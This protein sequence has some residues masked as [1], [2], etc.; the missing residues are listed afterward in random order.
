MPLMLS[1]NIIQMSRKVSILSRISSLVTRKNAKDV[2]KKVAIISQEELEASKRDVRVM[3]Q[4]Y[5]DNLYY[6]R[7]HSTEPN[8]VK[9]WYLPE[10]QDNWDRPIPP[11]WEAWLRYRRNDAPTCDE[12]NLNIALAELKK[13]RAKELEMKELEMK[14]D[15]TPLLSEG[16]SKPSAELPRPEKSDTDRRVGEEKPA[17]PRYDDIPS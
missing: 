2:S 16:T 10:V 13:I 8:K 1:N 14:G 3:G 11:E 9:R 4:D 15:R 5:L 7:N 12:I 17:W 6:E